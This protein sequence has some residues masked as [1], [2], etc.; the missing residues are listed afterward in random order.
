MLLPELPSQGAKQFEAR[1]KPHN[2]SLG[3]VGQ[4][5]PNLVKIQIMFDVHRL[6][7][8]GPHE[9]EIRPYKPEKWQQRFQMRRISKDSRR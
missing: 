7:V 4:I 3:I 5:Y 6:K 9:L 1:C 2:Q 8:N